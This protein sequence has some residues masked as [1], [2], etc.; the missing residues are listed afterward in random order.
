LSIDNDSSSSIIP[1]AKEEECK[2]HSYSSRS[3]LEVVVD[4]W[5]SF[6]EQCFK[7]KLAKCINNYTIAQ[8]NRIEATWKDSYTFDC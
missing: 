8:T 2:R 6:E 4:R 1:L 5:Y 7:T 3:H